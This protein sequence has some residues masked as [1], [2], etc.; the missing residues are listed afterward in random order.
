MNE[1]SHLCQV[2]DASEYLPDA[3]KMATGMELCRIRLAPRRAASPALGRDGPTA[4]VSP[5]RASD[6]LQDKGLV[7]SVMCVQLDKEGSEMYK[8]NRGTEYTEDSVFHST[9]GGHLVVP[10]DKWAAK[11][12]VMGEAQPRAVWYTTDWI[13]TTAAHAKGMDGRWMPHEPNLR[14]VLVV[15][16]DCNLHRHSLRLTPN[17]LRSITFYACVVA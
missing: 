3:W 14:C 2:V 16:S 13:A 8:S 12:R 6:G 17:P 1:R 11:I 4:R 7:W 15:L 10:Y 9:Q 5:R